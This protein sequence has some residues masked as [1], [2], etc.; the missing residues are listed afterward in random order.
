MVQR[1]AGIDDILDHQHIAPRDL[2]AQILENPHLAAGVI[3]S[4]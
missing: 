1:E 2:A 4:P 3:V